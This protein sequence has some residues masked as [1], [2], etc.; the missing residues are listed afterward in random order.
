MP[1]PA[2]TEFC[3]THQWICELDAE[4]T[5]DHECQQCPNH[6]RRQRREQIAARVAG[7]RVYTDVL[8]TTPDVD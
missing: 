6:L 3:P 7:H 8:E 1:Q 2:C 4:H 5:E